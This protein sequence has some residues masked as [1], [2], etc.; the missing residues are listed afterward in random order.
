M[1]RIM[2]QCSKEGDASHLSPLTNYLG[3][4]KAGTISLG[5]T[6]IYTADAVTRVFCGPAVRA[7]L[8]TTLAIFHLNGRAAEQKTSFSL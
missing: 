6:L 4:F 7:L 3:L 8:W 1:P 5:Y 2:V